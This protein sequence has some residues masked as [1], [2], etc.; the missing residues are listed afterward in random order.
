MKLTR[1]IDKNA[2][3]EEDNSAR[4]MEAC[5]GLYQCCHSLKNYTDILKILV[6]LNMQTQ[7]K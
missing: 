5:I 6:L 7:V 2:S 4:D 1:V 3:A